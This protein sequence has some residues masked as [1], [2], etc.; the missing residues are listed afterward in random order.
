MLRAGTTW[1]G[2]RGVLEGGEK[3]VYVGVEVGG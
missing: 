2:T 1:G 3:S